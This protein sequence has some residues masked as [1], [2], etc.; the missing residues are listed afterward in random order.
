M[1]LR[2]QVVGALATV[3]DPELDRSLV[4]LGFA[5]ATVEHGGRVTVE[6]RLQK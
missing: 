2:R 4:E 6:L 1:S 3:T 5:R